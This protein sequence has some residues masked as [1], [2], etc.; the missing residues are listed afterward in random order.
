MGDKRKN[1]KKQQPKN[2]HVMSE[3]TISPLLQRYSAL[4]VLRMLGEIANNPG[5]NLDWNELARNTSTEITNP[6][7]YQMLWRHLAYGAPLADVGDEEEPL[8]DDSDLECETEVFPSVS[9]KDKL[10]AAACV[11]ILASSSHCERNDPKDSIVEAPLIVTVPNRH[12]C[13]PPEYVTVPVFIPRNRGLVTGRAR[14]FWSA[15]EDEM[16]KAAV[17]KYGEGN[18]TNVVKEVSIG[19]KT[20]SQ[21]S[22]RWG[23]LKKNAT[24]DNVENVPNLPADVQGET[25]IAMSL[26]IDGPKFKIK[27]ASRAAGASLMGARKNGSPPNSESERAHMV[28]GA[29]PANK[30]SVSQNYITNAQ[31]SSLVAEIG[32]LWEVA[33]P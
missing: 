31:S 29:E 19:E 1:K 16:L 28:L 8:D 10:E 15:E 4:T 20:P 7:E 25:R 27:Q 13:E 24:L 9:F 6:R 22:Q 18:W 30:D 5:E 17:K 14:Q 33:C 23:I 21:L 11:K 3:E 12:P 26:A 2:T 32:W